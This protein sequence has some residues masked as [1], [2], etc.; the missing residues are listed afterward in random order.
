MHWHPQQH[1]RKFNWRKNCF[2]SSFICRYNDSIAF[3]DIACYH[4][5]RFICE[6]SEALLEEAV[7][8]QNA[9]DNEEES[10]TKKKVDE[11]ESTSKRAEVERTT[12]RIQS[13]T[14][15]TE[16]TTTKIEIESENTSRRTK[17]VETIKSRTA[18]TKKPNQ[19]DGEEPKKPQRRRKIVR[20]K[21]PEKIEGENFNGNANGLRLENISN[22]SEQPE[23]VP[24][25][26]KTVEEVNLALTVEDENRSENE[27][28]NSTDDPIVEVEAIEE[29]ETT[30]FT[31]RTS[32]TTKSLFR[33][34]G[35]RGRSRF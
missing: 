11:V 29:V 35:R 30:T 25:K 27:A 7:E 6:D 34:R 22:E 19:S 13:R 2:S 10:T 18:E 32:S 21:Q 1:V 28:L 26:E 3:H 16:T 12:K 33:N 17:T 8:I 5:T 9:K 15:I 23:N 20:K 4:R 24:E 31:E 14:K